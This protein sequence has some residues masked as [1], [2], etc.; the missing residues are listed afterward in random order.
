MAEIGTSQLPMRAGRW[1]GRSSGSVSDRRVLRINGGYV[2]SDGSEI[3]MVPGFRCVIDC[4]S[5][6]VTAGFFR[7]YYGARRPVLDRN[8]G[9]TFYQVNAGSGTSYVARSSRVPLSIS[10]SLLLRSALCTS[11]ACGWCAACCA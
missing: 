9:T 5:D 7:Q 11:T 4:V 10:N 8:G 6:P 1:P 3:R 2:A